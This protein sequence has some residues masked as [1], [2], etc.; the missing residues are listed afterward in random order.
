MN[1]DPQD[2][3]LLADVGSSSQR[4]F[5][6]RFLSGHNLEL[7]FGNTARKAFSSLAGMLV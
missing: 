7:S 1:L 4:R 3:D 5:L 2:A 6:K